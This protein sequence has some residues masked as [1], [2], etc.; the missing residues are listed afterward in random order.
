VPQLDAVDAHEG[1]GK[2]RHEG[3]RLHQVRCYH[4]DQRSIPVDGDAADQD[5]QHL[6][7]RLDRQDGAPAG[8]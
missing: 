3:G 2:Q 4:H 5:Q 6:R 8:R 1:Q 7:D